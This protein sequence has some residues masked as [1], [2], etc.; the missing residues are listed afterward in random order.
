MLT[1]N[2]CD[3]EFQ[4]QNTSLHTF[5]GYHDLI[6]V[7]AHG[8]TELRIKLPAND[9]SVHLRFKVLNALIA[10][11]EHPT[12]EFSGELPEASP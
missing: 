4:L 5:M 1:G 12:I 8:S 3:A 10:P 6:T 2:N 7:P 9:G 11:K